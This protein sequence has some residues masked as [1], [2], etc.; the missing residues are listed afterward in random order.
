M[1][2]YFGIDVEAAL[3]AVH[4]ERDAEFARE[5]RL[6]FGKAG[7]RVKGCRCTTHFTCGACLDHGQ[8]RWKAAEKAYND[9]LQPKESK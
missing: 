1:T 8:A 4:A 5:Q 9:S 7:P 3:A 6:V 2:Y